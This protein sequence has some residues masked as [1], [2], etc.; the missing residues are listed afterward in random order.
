MF[1]Q[2]VRRNLEQRVATFAI[3]LAS[4]RQFCQ[5]AEVKD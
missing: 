2:R 5:L 4:L 1:D 3:K